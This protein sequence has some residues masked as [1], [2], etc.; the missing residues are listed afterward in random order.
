MPEL[1]NNL[2]SIGQLQAKNL[3]IMFQ[4]GKCKVFHPE[5]GL[6]METDMAAN[7]MFI[8]NVV[9]Q[10]NSSTCFNTVTEDE[11]Y[12]WHCR[13]GHL[14]FKGLQT[15][16]LKRMVTALPHLKSSTKTCRDCLVG[17]Q[18]RESFP[19]HSTWRANHILQLVH[20]D[21][22]G[23][24]N[25]EFNSGKRYFLTLTDDFSR[26]TWV[27]FL[28]AKSEALGAFK[29]FQ[30][31]VEKETSHVIKGLRTD[32]GGEFTSHEFT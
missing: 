21:I 13:Y 32:R 23:P 24:I 29:S 28:T 3:T 9:A 14:G 6:L 1:K 30:I 11:G 7:R 15:L 17:K 26:K 2:L 5:K 18:H 22:C 20:A 27:Y 10:P 8:L 19:S 12:L 31:H 4:S 16:D 25:P